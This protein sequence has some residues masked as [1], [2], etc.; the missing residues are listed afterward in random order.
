L[1]TISLEIWHAFSVNTTSP[2]DTLQYWKTFGVLK[3]ASFNGMPIALTDISPSGSSGTVPFSGNAV[4][5]HATSPFT[6]TYTVNAVAQ[7]AKIVNNMQTAMAVS[8]PK[9]PST[10]S[11]GTSNSTKA[12][13]GG[14]VT[15]VHHKHHGKSSV[16]TSNSTSK[17]RFN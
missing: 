11:V 5:L 4:V 17:S 16:G 12:T 9:T 7:P 13:S 6:V 2:G 14:T 15:V 1:F 8:T 10:T 3:T